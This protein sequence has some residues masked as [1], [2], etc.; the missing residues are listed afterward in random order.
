[1]RTVLSIA[2][3]VVG[4]AFLVGVACFGFCLVDEYTRTH[5]GK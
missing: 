5:T 1:M 3:K 4:A 2:G